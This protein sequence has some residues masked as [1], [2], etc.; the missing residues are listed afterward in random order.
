MRQGKVS[1]WLWM[2]VSAVAGPAL[3]QTPAGLG[4]LSDH[5]I[6]E[7]ARAYFARRNPA[8]GDRVRRVTP[9]GTPAGGEVTIVHTDEDGALIARRYWVLRINDRYTVFTEPSAALNHPVVLDYLAREYLRRAYQ[10]NTL[11]VHA[12]DWTRLPTSDTD[13]AEI[14]VQFQIE[15]DKSWDEAFQYQATMQFERSNYQWRLAGVQVATGRGESFGRAR[16]LPMTLIESTLQR[17]DPQPAVRVVAEPPPPAPAV[18]EQAGQ[19]G[20]G[21]VRWPLV[22]VGVLIILAGGAVMIVPSKR[23]RGPGGPGGPKA[24]HKPRSAAGKG[25]LH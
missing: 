7:A 6:A 11:Q 5:P 4:E 17:D 2:V 10:D 1:I 15:P 25:L 16:P 12:I 18:E 19:G 23:K 3:A 22:L 8:L 14:V 9:S 24:P 21:G 20:A 13:E